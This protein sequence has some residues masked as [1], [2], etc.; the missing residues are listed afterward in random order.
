[1][2]KILI[3][4]LCSL[5]AIAFS[6]DIHMAGD[7]TMAGYG[8]DKAPMAGWGQY[9]PEFC[10]EGVKVNNHAKSGYTLQRFRGRKLWGNLLKDVKAGDYVIIQFG[11]NDQKLANDEK[12]GPE[13]S[14]EIYKSC[15]QTCIDDVKKKQANPIVVTS[16]VRC[17]F[18][19]EGK[20]EDPTNLRAY[21][22]AAIEFAKEKEVPVID[23]NKIS[24]EKAAEM[25]NQAFEKLYMVSA[26]KK[27]RT[28][29]REA[30]A[31]AYA[32][33]F[34]EAVKAEKLPL[35]ECFK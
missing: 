11:H 3:S 28:H 16:I 24:S 6:A 27:D 14:M 26:N 4:A 13:K 2:K 12:I 19:A 32:S 33:W 1:M 29:L 5:T 35:A 23:I 15:I 7:S 18:N 10:Q 31:K 21:C 25:G 17:T 22:D 8:E 30:G 9:L 34:I 20:L